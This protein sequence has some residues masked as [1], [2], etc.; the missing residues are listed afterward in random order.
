M[1]CLVCDERVG[2]MKQ[3]GKR[4]KYVDFFARSVTAEYVDSAFVFLYKTRSIS[5]ATSSVN[6]FDDEAYS[7]RRVSG[8]SCRYRNAD[9][10]A[11]LL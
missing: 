4:L 9:I 8:L 10:S 2:I 11:R 1:T 3:C 6:I 7:E 5:A